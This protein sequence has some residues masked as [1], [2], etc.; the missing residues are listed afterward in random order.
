MK[1]LFTALD[2]PQDKWN[3]VKNGVLVKPSAP[4]Q[5]KYILKLILTKSIKQPFPLDLRKSDMVPIYYPYHIR[6]PEN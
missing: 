1:I 4:R 5:L 2:V 6:L 3:N